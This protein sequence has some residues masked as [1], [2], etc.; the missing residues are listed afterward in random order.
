MGLCS[1]RVPFV[2]GASFGFIGDAQLSALERLLKDPRMARRAVLVA[3]H[4][5]PFKE[6][7]RRD[8]PSHGLYQVERLLSLLPGPRFA[9]LHGH[10]HHRYHHPATAERPHIFSA[11]SS[12][13][14]GREGY[15][16]IETKDGQVVG[17]HKHVPGGEL[18]PVRAQA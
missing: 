15:W 7:G 10:I 6:S 3:V 8:S 13:Q 17:G 16:L 9:V 1:A 18:A 5:G 14:A 4:H 11:G 2:P 12:T